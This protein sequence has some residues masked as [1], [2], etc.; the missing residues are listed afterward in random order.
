MDLHLS[1]KGEYFEQLKAGTKPFEYRR[2]TP[3][4]KKRIEGR[5]YENIIITHGYPKRDDLSKRLTFPW[6]GYEMQTI[7]HPHFDNVP[8]DVYA[9]IIKEAK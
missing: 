5:E 9:I 4:W 7:T 3:Y 1:V 2:Y 6:R 8:Q